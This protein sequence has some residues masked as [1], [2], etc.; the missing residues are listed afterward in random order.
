MAAIKEVSMSAPMVSRRRRIKK[1]EL[2]LPLFIV[3]IAVVATL[4]EPRFMSASNL[5]NLGKQMVPLAIAAVGQCLAVISGGLDLSIAAVMS[6]AGVSGILVMEQYGV[7]AGI[8]TMLIT[9][10][11]MGLFSGA[12]ISYMK[13]TPLIVTLGMLS[14]SQALALIL[15]HGVPIYNIPESF[16]NAVGFGTLLGLPVIIWIGGATVVAAWILLRKTVFG[17]YVYAIGSNSSAATKSGLNVPRYTTLVYGFSGLTAG[18]CAIVM[19]SWTSAAEP[20]ASPNLTL[21][22]IAAV[23]LGGVALKGGSGGIHHVLYGVIILSMLTNAMNITGVSTFYQML[24][25][26]LVIIL[27]VMLDRFR[28]KAN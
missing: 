13:T 21:E 17:R 11:V 2:I 12:I 6:L 4:I 10:S 23:V 24:A 16:A 14:I 5:A 28:G 26:G 9:G 25:V 8:A 18:I 15:S 20:V 3:V 19:T 7:W 22:S 27:A 1:G